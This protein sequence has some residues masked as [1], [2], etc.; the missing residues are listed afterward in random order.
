MKY[1]ELIRNKKLEIEVFK[2][3]ARKTVDDLEENLDI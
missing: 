2:M 1:W 3:R